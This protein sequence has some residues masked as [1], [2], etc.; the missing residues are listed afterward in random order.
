MMIMVMMSTAVVMM[1]I[2]V[3]VMV[4]VVPKM[5][6]TI[7]DFVEDEAKIFVGSL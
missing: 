5:F 6:Q 4:I 3:D 7:I 2:L 1:M